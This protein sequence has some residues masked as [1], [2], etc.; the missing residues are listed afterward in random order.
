L[1]IKQN[2]HC[3]EQFQGVSMKS[4]RLW[5][6]FSRLGFRPRSTFGLAPARRGLLRGAEKL[7]LL[8]RFTAYPYSQN[9]S[10]GACRI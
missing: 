6:E 9:K 10:G 3:S 7:T 2:F 1:I 8:E 5:Q 4:V